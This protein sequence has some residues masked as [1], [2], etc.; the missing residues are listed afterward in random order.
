M[1]HF[2][3]NAHRHR[4]FGWHHFGG[5]WRW[6]RLPAGADLLSVIPIAD[7]CPGRRNDPICDRFVSS[8]IIHLFGDHPCLYDNDDR[9]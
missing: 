4:V 7:V 8:R 3:A 6:G 1:A 5:A 9:A 2:A